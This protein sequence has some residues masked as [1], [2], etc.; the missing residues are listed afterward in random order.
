MG[1]DTK[2]DEEARRAAT[3]QLIRELIAAT[4]RELQVRHN[5]RQERRERSL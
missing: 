5:A 1:N 3:M 2:D 4:L